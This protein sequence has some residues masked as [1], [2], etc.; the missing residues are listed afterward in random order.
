MCA[1]WDLTPNAK[2]EMGVHCVSSCM[3]QIMFH[4]SNLLHPLDGCL[5]VAL[6][7]LI[8]CAQWAS[9]VVLLCS[10]LHPCFPLGPC[11]SFCL[12]VQIRSMAFDLLPKFSKLIP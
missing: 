12:F 7:F 10:T 11:R 4:A 9:G 3:V 6:S 5:R 2:M 1:V 8:I